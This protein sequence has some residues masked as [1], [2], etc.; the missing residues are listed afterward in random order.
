MASSEGRA[1][2]AALDALEDPA[3]QI[4]PVGRHLAPDEEDLLS[5][6]CLV[7]ALFEVIYRSSQ[8]QFELLALARSDKL[9]PEALL[10]LPPAEL[11][12]DVSA[13]SRVFFD[14]QGQLLSRSAVLN[15]TFDGS[16]HVGGADGDLMLGDCLV[17]VKTT[18]DPS[19]EA[20]RALRQLLGYVLLDYHDEYR[21][22]SVGIYFS[23]Q[24]LL[25][26]WPL[27]ALIARAT[28]AE[29]EPLQISRDTVLLRGAAPAP[30]TLAQLRDDFRALLGRD[31]E[32][33]I[34][35]MLKDW[36]GKGPR[37][38]AQGA[39]PKGTRVAKL[40]AAVGDSHPDGALATVV[41]SVPVDLITRKGYAY[42]VEWD[43][44]PGVPVWIIDYR[45]ESWR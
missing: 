38:D 26:T 30:P 7:L 9:S 27:D 34:R 12:G 17:E 37:G 42:C 18:K 40:M 36:R 32:R 13:L 45:L 2:C 6:W 21:I 28:W 23:R 22:R 39:W 31:A 43:D 20:L 24:A 25:Y 4:Q 16:A 15:P 44:L 5:R 14:K 33:L 1:L 3:Q 8:M 29:G 10:E 41:G 35:A 19:P 11:V